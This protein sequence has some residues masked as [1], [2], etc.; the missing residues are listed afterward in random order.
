[1]TIFQGCTSPLQRRGLPMLIALLFCFQV[2]AQVATNF[3]APVTAEDFYNAGTELLEAKKFAEAEKMFESALAAQEE[4]VQA[5]ALYNLGEARFADGADRLKK[6][7]D[8]Q[9]T[10]AQGNGALAA[11]GKAVNTMQSALA[12]PDMQRMVAAYLEGRGAR[13]QV[14]EAEKAVQAA[15]E[16]YGATLNDWRDSAENF[17]SAVE[18]NPAGTNAA[19]NALIVE[20]QLAALVDRMR[21]MQGAAASLGNQKRQL[22]Q[23]LGKLRGQIPGSAVQPGGEGDDDEE[24]LQPESLAGQKEG[25]SREGN[26]MQMSISPDLA[27]QILNSLAIDGAK[28]LSINQQQGAPPGPK[29]GRNW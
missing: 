24:G 22:D 8:A 3:P 12:T 14:R 7:P 26:E 21:R 10:D 1:M 27:R 18:L 2:P 15:M 11:G 16:S 23:L 29:T 19:Q 4:R 20:R 25:A 5:P 13:R 17:N 6:G 28:R 9:K